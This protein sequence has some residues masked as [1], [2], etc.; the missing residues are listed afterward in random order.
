[1]GLSAESGT[2]SRR[3]ATTYQRL[4]R[5]RP[6]SNRLNRTASSRCLPSQPSR[7]PEPRSWRA[8]AGESPSRP[9]PTH[10]FRRSDGEKGCSC[11][12]QAPPRSCAARSRFGMRA[13]I[14]VRVARDEN[15][16]RDLDRRRLR[17]LKPFA[18]TG[19]GSS[20]LRPI[21]RPPTRGFCRGRLCSEEA[22]FELRRSRAPGID[23][24]HGSE[25]GDRDGRVGTYSSRALAVDPNPR[26]IATR[27]PAREPSLP[28]AEYFPNR[29]TDRKSST[30]H[31]LLSAARSPFLW[32][33]RRPDRSTELLP[34]AARSPC[35]PP[36]PNPAPRRTRSSAC[37]SSSSTIARP[38]RDGCQ[39]PIQ[40]RPRPASRHRG[41]AQGVGAERLPRGG[42]RRREPQQV[43]RHRRRHLREGG[44]V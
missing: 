16:T 32:V 28:G 42:D 36:P 29:Q 38:A 35:A 43:L 19:E 44:Q 20:G 13:S 17:T 3:D 26:R 34:P 8:P 1:M 22:G 7:R 27:G 5:P 41:V 30:D 33:S 31:P 12:F 15:R 40:R 24:S 21:F 6:V 23:G 11:L 37:P 10:P 2:G 4:T 14:D 9:T 18:V 25:V 39:R